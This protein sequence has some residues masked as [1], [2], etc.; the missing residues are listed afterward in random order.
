M[1][2]IYHIKIPKANI[3]VWA[4]LES[5]NLTGTHKDRSMGPWIEH[6]AKQ[7][8][9]EFAIA[10]SG[11]SAISA[12]KYCTEKGVKL[13]IFVSGNSPVL[14]Y[15]RQGRAALHISKTPR[16]DAL[17]FC[18]K[19][20]NVINL[21]ASTD[22]IAL[23]GY[24][25]ISYELIGQTAACL[26]AGRRIDNIFIPTSSGAT[27]EGLYLGFK[28]KMPKVPA[29]YAVQTTKVHPIASYFDKGFVKEAESKAKAI[30]DNIAHRRDRVI[31][32]CEETGGGGLVISNK[33]LERAKEIL[34]TLLN[35]VGWHSALAFSGFLKWQVQ[36]SEKARKQNSVCL[37]TD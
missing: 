35:K 9:K 17:Q 14:A 19:Y 37:F 33:E 32:I 24:K 8:V 5:E 13:H 15:L 31:R 12:A 3:D 1:T 22:D 34:G 4:K 2:T 6:Y 7:G 11:N 18:R 16:R 36:N 26:P 25:Q 28:E 10:S 20:K 29:F 23:V 21:R 27:L 30:V